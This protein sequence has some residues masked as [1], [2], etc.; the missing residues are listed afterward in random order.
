MTHREGQEK[1][2]VVVAVSGGFDP[3]HIGHV[4]LFERAKA[5]GTKLVV[6]LN[7]DN[8]L[9]KKKHH[10][11]MTQDERREVI[12]GLR[13]VDEVVLTEHGVDPTDMSVCDA[14]RKVRPHIFANGGDRH[15]HNIPEVPVCEEIGAKMIFN[16]GEGGKVQSSSWLLTRYL[17]A[18]N[19]IKKED[20]IKNA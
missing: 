10:I 20:E 13:A 14:L 16:I 11:F 7:N 19:G 15:Q 6:I 8:W 18:V 5:L 2:E 17:E 1:Q 12:A 9:T 4:R 3:V